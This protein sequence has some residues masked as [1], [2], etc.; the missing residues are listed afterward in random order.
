MSD[1]DLVAKFHGQADAVIGA[2]GSQALIETCW[3]LGRAADVGALVRA[4]RAAG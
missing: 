2:A 1:A 4:G 3:G